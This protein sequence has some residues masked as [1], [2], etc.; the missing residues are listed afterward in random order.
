MPNI[1]GILTKES[2]Y[3]PHVNTETD[4]AFN[5]NKRII[6]F[7]ADNVDLGDSMSYYL[8]RKQ[9]ILGYKDYKHALQDLLNCILNQPDIKNIR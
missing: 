2:V 5:A 3:S 9:W 6:P 8:A 7:F 4:I 1:S